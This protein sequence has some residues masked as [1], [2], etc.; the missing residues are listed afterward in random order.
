MTS[1]RLVN[2][3][4]LLNAPAMTVV[5]AL[6]NRI[7][8]A[9]WCRE[10]SVDQTCARAI[11]IHLVPTSPN[12]LIIFIIRIVMARSSDKKCIS[13]MWCVT[14]TIQNTL[15]YRWRNEMSPVKVPALI[16]TI[17]LLWRSLQTKQPIIAQQTS[18]CKYVN[19]IKRICVY[20]TG[21]QR[22]V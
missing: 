3:V 10:S 14:L 5:I 7:L 20:L 21:K 8:C 13:I 4:V 11:Y 12:I 16:D 17:R 22:N 18:T 2:D 19:Q 6:L 1:Y 15:T 9:S